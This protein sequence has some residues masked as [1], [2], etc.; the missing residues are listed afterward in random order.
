MIQHS[1][2]LLLVWRV[3][4]FEARHLGAAT[5]EPVHFFLGL[6]KSVDLA[7]DKLVK[8][9]ETNAVATAEI[10]RDLADVRTA[11]QRS[12]VE[13]T[14]V[15][16]KLRK[17][18]GKTNSKRSEHLRRSSPARAIFKAT[19]AFVHCGTVKPVH[20]LSILC[21][22][23]IPVVFQVFQDFRLKDGLLLQVSTMIALARLGGTG[24]SQSGKPTHAWID[25]VEKFKKEGW[26]VAWTRSIRDDT[27]FWKVEIRRNGI[28][29]IVVADNLP[30]ALQ[31]LEHEI[32]K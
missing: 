23:S 3:A 20:L 16:R 13:T 26:A 7:L 30:A 6:L 21:E 2:S 15:R 18:I 14:P 11:F 10:A 5:I 31:E 27:L 1:E 19:E 17:L 32:V 4:E 8:S 9:T 22:T 25:T 29:R 12:G 28:R 24:D